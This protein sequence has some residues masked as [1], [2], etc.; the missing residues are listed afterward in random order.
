MKILDQ[1]AGT[2]EKRWTEHDTHAFIWNSIGCIESAIDFVSCVSSSPAT[3]KIRL[4]LSFVLFYRAGNI[5]NSVAVGVLRL[6]T[7]YLRDFFGEDYSQ[8]NTECSL[9]NLW[10]RIPLSVLAV[11]TAGKYRDKGFVYLALQFLFRIIYTIFAQSSNTI[12]AN[13]SMAFISDTP[14]YSKLWISYSSWTLNVKFF[15]P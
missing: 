10:L 6:A 3:N 15:K 8:V 2:S 9:I 7:L 11:P 4:R 5:K 13:S 1:I 12:Q 14:N